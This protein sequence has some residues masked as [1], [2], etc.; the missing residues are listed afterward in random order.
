MLKSDYDYLKHYN[1]SVVINNYSVPRLLQIHNINDG[2]NLISCILS[3]TGN[4]FL[5]LF[6]SKAENLFRI[7]D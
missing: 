1:H 4:N 7:N 6:N 2:C 5:A 3:I